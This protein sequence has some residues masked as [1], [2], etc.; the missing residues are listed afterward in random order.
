MERL[1]PFVKA[2][3]KAHPEIKIVGSSGPSADG[4]HFDY[5]WPE[6]RRLVPT[7]ST[8]TITSR[9]NGSATMPQDMTTTTVAPKVFAGEYACHLRGRK[10]NHFDASLLEAAFMTGLERNADIVQ[11]ATYA[12]LLAHEEGWQWRPDMVWFNGDTVNLTAS[13]FVQRMYARNKGTNV[14]SLLVDG[15]PL[16]GQDG[17]Y[18]SA[19]FDADTDTYIVKIVNINKEEAPFEIILDKLPKKAVLGSVECVAMG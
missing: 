2:L 14:A 5:L 1:E 19:V 17:L 15:K 4:K 3:R 12:P 7:L 11:M 10:F 9:L 8:S 18:A 13:Y 16:T 6:M